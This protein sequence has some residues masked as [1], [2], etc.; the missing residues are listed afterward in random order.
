MLCKTLFQCLNTTDSLW[1]SQEINSFLADGKK[2]EKMTQKSLQHHLCE[3]FFTVCLGWN[4]QS[5]CM[6]VSKLHTLHYIWFRPYSLLDITDTQTD[7]KAS[8]L[9]ARAVKNEPYPEADAL[10]RSVGQ[11]IHI[12]TLQTFNGTHSST[13]RAT[14]KSSFSSTS[15]TPLRVSQSSPCTC[16]LRA[17]ILQL[18]IFW[19]LY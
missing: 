4:V 3:N 19:L 16:L 10:H 13:P 7:L 9:R 1:H 14:F 8:L 15:P 18:R 6:C 12:W 17:Y 11:I 2:S 5:V